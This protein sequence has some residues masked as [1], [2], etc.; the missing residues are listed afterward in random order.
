MSGANGSSYG[1]YPSAQQTTFVPDQLIAGNL[2]LVTADVTIGESQTLVR[3]SVVGKVTASGAYI[4]S[5][6]T[7][8]DGSQTPAAVMVD[9]VTTTASATGKGSIYK[10]GEFNSNYL[11]FDAS[12]TADTLAAAMAPPVFV[13]TA[14]SNDIV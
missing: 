5:V 2:K 4:L 12:W 1:F 10:M 7:A 3:G 13:K 11:S 9:A 6:A 14:L 8:T